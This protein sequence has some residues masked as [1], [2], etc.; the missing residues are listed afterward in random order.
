MPVMMTATTTAA[1][2]ITSGRCK[3][4]A[5]LTGAGCRFFAARPASL[6]LTTSATAV[7]AAQTLTSDAP[8]KPSTHPR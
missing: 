2:M 6:I 5:F 3:S 1:E 4:I 8:N 7:P